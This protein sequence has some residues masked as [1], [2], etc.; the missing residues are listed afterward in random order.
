M[1]WTHS[2][3]RSRSTWETPITQRLRGSVTV[4]GSIQRTR[5]S[6]RFGTPRVPDTLRPSLYFSK[7]VKGGYAD[8]Q[9][10][11]EAWRSFSLVAPDRT[12]EVAQRVIVREEFATNSA[13]RAVVPFLAL[14]P[15]S[16]VLV[17]WI[18]ARVLRPL[19]SVTAE[20]RQWEK[21]GS[22]S[23]SLSHVPDEMMP[24]A[25]AMN[26][27][28]TRLREQLEFR[29]AFISDAAHE[30]RT[31]LTAL[32]LQGRN[33]RTAAAT[34]ERE[35]LAAEME[36]GFRRMSEMIT[37]MLSLARVDG[38]APSAESRL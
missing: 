11:G 1:R 33:L 4:I 32:R 3:R 29:K 8:V 18:V 31:P 37:Q 20:L 7:P 26:D 38:E 15:L 36:C 10:S 35:V 12:V 28:I 25:L 2:S 30:L 9:T 34:S 16:A 14:I 19:R 13:L 22:A 21:K 23:L 24:L 5:S 17:G 27:L 6:S